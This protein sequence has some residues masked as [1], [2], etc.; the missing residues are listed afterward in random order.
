VRKG[1][2]ICLLM[3]G[4]WMCPSTSFALAESHAPGLVQSSCSNAHGWMRISTPGIAGE[5]SCFSPEIHDRYASI[6]AGGVNGR[7]DVT[8]QMNFLSRSGRHTCKVPTVLIDLQENRTVWSAYRIGSAHF[9]DC[10][11]TQIFENERKLWKG[12]AIARLVIVKGDTATGSPRKLH[13]VKDVSGNPV[14]RTVEVEWEF[15]QLFTLSA[16]SIPTKSRE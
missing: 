12:H 6:S 5:I 4:L 15:D 16:D 10:S 14:T 3:F 8:I 1:Q 9:G 2:L 13:T 11:I 7:D